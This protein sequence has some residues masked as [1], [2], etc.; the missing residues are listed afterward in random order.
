MSPLNRKMTQYHRMNMNWNYNFNNGMSIPNGAHQP[1]KMEY[2]APDEGHQ[3][4]EI[5]E[6]SPLSSPKPEH[7]KRPLNVFMVWSKMERKKFC[8]A[9]PEVHNATISQTLAARWKLMTVEEKA[10]FVAEAERLRQLHMEK[11]PHYKYQPRRKNKKN[12]PKKTENNDEKKGRKTQKNRNF[13]PT[14]MTE[15][16][17]MQNQQWNNQNNWMGMQ[18]QNSNVSMNPFSGFFNQ[19]QQQ[20]N[21]LMGMSMGMMVSMTPMV[22]MMQQNQTFDNQFFQPNLPPTADQMAN[23][24]VHNQNSMNPFYNPYTHNHFN[25]HQSHGMFAPGNAQFQ[26]QMNHHRSVSNG[27]SFESLNSMNAS[28]ATSS[29]RDTP[30]T[31]Y[32]IT[33]EFSDI[34]P[35]ISF[36]S[37]SENFM[38]TLQF[39]QL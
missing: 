34:N 7:I 25:S 31:S 11:Y 30:S 21:G 26:P 4:N 24:M 3:E 6:S 2:N 18:Q 20:Q 29:S 28:P 39:N 13:E 19:Q 27:S 23:S 1:I 5:D 35:T 38:N 10:P 22:P 15:N 17:N 37:G 14:P 32:G 16:K 33:D 8:E 9:H 36:E 12:K